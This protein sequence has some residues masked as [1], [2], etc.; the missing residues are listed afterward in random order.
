[1]T[2]T[3]KFIIRW[4]ASWLTGTAVF[5]AFGAFTAWEAAPVAWGE[6]LRGFVAGAFVIWTL[7]VSVFAAASAE[8]GDK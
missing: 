5:Y 2:D 4:V 3:Q 1:M 8:Y 7:M 6:K